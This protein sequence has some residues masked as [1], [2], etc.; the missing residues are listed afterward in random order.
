MSCSYPRTLLLTASVP[1]SSGVG[2]LFL[3]ELCASMPSDE[4]C[5]AGLASAFDAGDVAQFSA[6]PQAHLHVAE[7]L[8]GR[9][10]P[11]LWS[12]AARHTRFLMQRWSLD[13]RL[14]SEIIRFGEQCSV[15]QVWTVL[16]SPLT[17]R[18]SRAIAERM[19]LPLLSTVWDPPEGVG[20][21]G[22]LDRLSRK[23]AYQDFRKAIQAS[24]RV[25]VI[26]E[27]MAAEYAR[28]GAS[29][30]VVLRHGISSTSQRDVVSSEADA[31][32][33]IGFCGSLYAESEWRAFLGGLE[34]LNWQV[35]GKP[36]RLIVAGGRVPFL[37][38][39]CPCNVEFLGW[40]NMDEVIDV[41]ASCHFCYLPYWFN[42]A[43]RDS[44]RLC[45]PTKLTTYL[46]AGR[47]VF[48]HGPADAAVVDF[49][50][51]FDIA[52]CCHTLDHTTVARVVADFARASNR[53]SF[54]LCEVRRAVDEELNL[55][56]FHAR[57]RE[58][59]TGVRPDGPVERSTDEVSQPTMASQA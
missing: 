51:R 58:L 35:D 44:V 56:T 23:L 53:S 43:Y 31:E 9:R 22:G 27:R 59:L 40:R 19:S 12:V 48:Y 42:S 54:M 47:P 10:G 28:L 49:F 29:R 18:L 25:S 8:G 1:G 32:L 52:K 46:T 3:R 14:T 6:H 11:R 50:E 17:Y 33:R 15:E 2:P 24:T 21:H 45:F 39:R 34:E 41:M 37:S 55:H 26:S 4:L 38:A 57:F 20:L 30:T 36:I 13:R 7:T 5:I 16:N